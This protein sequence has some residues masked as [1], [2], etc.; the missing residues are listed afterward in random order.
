MNGVMNENQLAV[1]REYEFDNPLIHKID[2]IIDNC[3][4]DCHKKYFHTFEFECVYNIKLTNIGNNESVNIT[5][6]DKSMG[7]YELNKKLTVA[8]QNSFI[9]N[10]INKLTIKFYSHLRYINICYYLKFQIPMCHRL[11]FKISSQN[12]EYFQTHCNDL[13][14]GFNFACQKWINQ[15]K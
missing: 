5:I 4:R 14:N 11:F 10:Q 7:L 1:V 12:P 2:S 9:F 8:R 6:S 3:Y 13:N 15:L